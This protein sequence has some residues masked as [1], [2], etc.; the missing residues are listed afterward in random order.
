MSVAV[1]ILARR[2]E[3]GKGKRRL[4]ATLGDER[5]LQIYRA[6]IGRCAAAALSSGLPATVYFE[7]EPGDKNVWPPSRFGYATQADSPDLGVRIADAA[8]RSLAAHDAV[9][10]IGTD[11]PDLTADVLREAA[12]A[13]ETH[14]A[15]LGPSTDGGYYLLGV[16][17][18][19]P[20]LFDGI[21]WSTEEV[22]AQTRAVLAQAGLRYRELPPL[23]DV[24]E[25]ADWVAYLARAQSSAP[26]PS[27]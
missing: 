15:V 17:A 4:A 23:T 12:R 27:T 13:L 10:L 1:A 11:C 16:K 7:P 14:D 25:E 18:V 19:T 21:A 9:L 3:L 2:A 22:A 8:T 24:D 6:L 20:G 5:T 26:R